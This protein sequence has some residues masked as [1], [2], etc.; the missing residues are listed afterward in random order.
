MQIKA[1]LN[2]ALALCSLAT[3]AAAGI[4]VHFDLR[5]QALREVR[6]EAELR[7]R[8]AQAVRR[9]TTEHVRALVP[10]DSATFHPISVPS[11][12][13][14]TTMRYLHA[15]YPG[16]SYRE[17]ALNPT[18][19]ANLATGDAAEVVQAL[20]KDGSGTLQRVTGGPGEQVLHFA[21]AIRVNDPDCL[22]CHGSAA[23]APSALVMRYGIDGGFG[24]KVGEVIGAQIVS[25]PMSLAFERSNA[26][27]LRF[28]AGAVT[29]ISVMFVV[30]N[31]MLRRMVINPMTTRMGALKRLAAVDALTGAVNR[32][33]FNKFLGG[34]LRRAREQGTPLS[35]VMIDLDHFKQVND[36]F[37][38][39]A[40]DAALRELVRRVR[41]R[42]R[43]R[44][45][46]GRLGGEEF[47]LVLPN[48]AL[49]DALSAAKAVLAEVTDPPF[50]GVGQITASLGVAQWN[51]SE[52][53]SQLLERADAALYAAKHKGRARIE[54]AEVPV[55]AG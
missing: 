52:S 48:T 38:H 50:E 30:L 17:V 14:T 35:V 3:L 49:P 10:V 6:R 15:G 7:M 25:M 2:L 1:R 19:P 45:V 41:S 44:D 21:Q 47:A 53:L 37:G 8:A 55:P 33:G 32:R 5:E 18:N 40:G 29:V 43:G 31:V 51:G 28:L 13:A 26:T 42:S 23:T 24:W 22:A 4:A 46:L 39:A 20:R 54:C 27:L 9:Y 36:R 12:A 11:F 34:H 16:V